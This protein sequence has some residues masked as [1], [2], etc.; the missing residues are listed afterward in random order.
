VQPR[1]RMKP[2]TL[3]SLGVLAALAL[4]IH[5]DDAAAG[6]RTSSPV[7]VNTTSRYMYGNLG[8]AR[9]SVDT[10]QYLSCQVTTYTTAPGVSFTQ[11]G[12]Q[13]QDATGHVAACYLPNPTPGY[14][15]AMA[16][17]D[18]DSALFVTWDA[19]GVCNQ[20]QVQSTSTAEPKK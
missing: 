20:L 12:C 19:S 5:A 11:L 15:E 4:S 13:A 6:Q 17:I 7:V 3:A 8:T 2:T 10:T 18:S 14:L 16:A 9:N 1:L